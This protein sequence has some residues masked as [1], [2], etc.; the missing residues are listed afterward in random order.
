MYVCV[1]NEKGKILLHRNMHTDFDQFK[2]KMQ[3]LRS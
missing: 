2:K 1:L 3:P